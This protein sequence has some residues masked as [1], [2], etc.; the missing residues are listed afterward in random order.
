MSIG[1]ITHD[2]RP[3][4]IGESPRVLK[5]TGYTGK[6]VWIVASNLC[7]FDHYSGGEGSTQLYLAGGDHYVA[8][9]T[10]EQILE[11]LK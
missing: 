3:M 11:M 4:F 1:N 9:E 7:A 5:L 6:P 2:G 8:K 10:P